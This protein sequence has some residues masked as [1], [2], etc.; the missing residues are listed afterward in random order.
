MPRGALLASALLAVAS[1]TGCAST[2]EK[3]CA[4]L[5][6]QH[7]TLTD[8]AKSS[9]APGGDLFVDSLAVFGQ[10]RDEAPD[11]IRDEWDTYVFAWQDMA[12]AFE[13]AGVSP[14]DYHPGVRPAGVTDAQLKAI[15]D[16]AIE[17]Q[18][19]RVVDAGQGIEQHARDVCKVDLA[20]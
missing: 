8:L 17:L 11:G 13:E 12:D 16:A 10:L 5:E 14:Q 1:L 9:A 18:S 6:D 15:K 3:Y 19:E 7:Q 20:R 2:T 4:T